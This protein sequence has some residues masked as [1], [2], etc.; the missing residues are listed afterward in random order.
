MRALASRKVVMGAVLALSGAVVCSI[1]GEPRSGSA[2]MAKAGAAPASRVASAS[3][4][5]AEKI[6]HG[7]FDDIRL[8]RPM[9]EPRQVVLFL[10]GDNGWDGAVLEMTRALVERGALVVGIDTPRLFENLDA[11]G[12]GCVFPD[13]D[14]ENLSHYVQGYTRLSTYHTPLLLGYS[15]GAT[16]A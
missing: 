11:D 12:G 15:S 9:G 6:S 14:L 10:S 7:R 5:V 16:L 13:G 4:A 8:Y 3:R 2:G 1:A